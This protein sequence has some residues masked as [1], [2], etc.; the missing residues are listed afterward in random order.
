MELV[1]SF[2]PPSSALPTCFVLLPPAIAASLLRGE[3]LHALVLRLSLPPS[4]CRTVLPLLVSWAGG[5]SNGPSELGIDAAFAT[6]IGL[7]DGQAVCA[8]AIHHEPN[9]RDAVVSIVTSSESDYAAVSATAEF[10]EGALLHQI[11]VLYPGL[12]FPLCLPGR[13]VVELDVLLVGAHGE[14]PDFLYLHSG[15]DVTVLPPALPAHDDVAVDVATLPS[16]LRVLPVPLDLLSDYSSQLLA[17][18]EGR[19]SDDSDTIEHH[20]VFARR[21]LSVASVPALL[22][23]SSKFCVPRGHVYVPPHIWWELNLAMLDSL[24][25]EAIAPVIPEKATSDLCLLPRVHNDS[26]PDTDLRPPSVVYPGML[27]GRG[28]CFIGYVDNMPENARLLDKL[29]AAPSLAVDDAS[30]SYDALYS[31]EPDDELEQ[32]AVSSS[33]SIAAWSMSGGDTLSFQDMEV[34]DTFSERFLHFQSLY[35]TWPP[36]QKVESVCRALQC[37]R[38]ESPRKFLQRVVQHLELGPT[39]DQ[40]RVL[41]LRGGEG[42]GK[43]NLA[44]ACAT[45]LRHKPPMLHTVWVRWRVHVGEPLTASISRV[46]AAFRIAREGSPSLIVFDDVDAV[47]SLDKSTDSLSDSTGG[48]HGGAANAYAIAHCIACCLGQNQSKVRLLLLAKTESILDGEL[49]APG[50]VTCTE[51]IGALTG[52]DRAAILQSMMERS[53]DDTRIQRKE[54]SA[55]E[56]EEDIH[57]I[58]TEVGAVC[59]GFSPRDLNRVVQRAMFLRKSE[60][61]QNLSRGTVAQ[62]LADAAKATVP[63]ARIGVTFQTGSSVTGQTWDA[64]GGLWHAKAALRETF[65]LPARYPAMFANAPVRIPSGVLLYGPPGTGKS[66]LAT[67]GSRAC[68]LRSIT[69][70][71][72]EL[73][74]K[75]IGESEAEVRRLF[76]RASALSPCVVIF[77]ELDA[78]APR[79]GGETTGVAD[80]VVNTLLTSLDGVEGLCK[81]VFVV[82]T[83]SHP[84]L[85]DPAILRPGRIDRWVPVDF[86]DEEERGEI[87]ACLWKGMKIAD[88]ASC[89]AGLK[90]ISIATSGMSG[91]D[92]RGVLSDAALSAGTSASI[93]LEKLLSLVRVARP[94]VSAWERERYA[95][96][97]TLFGRKQQ[98][99]QGSKNELDG[100]RPVRVALQ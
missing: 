80:R 9:V 15:V 72:P 41:L 97:M 65:D 6:S 75:Y 42:F 100:K 76:Q 38:G 95:A 79:R 34:Q 63:Q 61:I 89:A 85:I 45:I 4:A 2:N 99:D 81:G 87:L 20:P 13:R 12:T 5:A 83:S 66:L 93:S 30:A 96:V 25:I 98:Q 50:L 10:T 33:S 69:V 55:A 35:R 94:S 43:T 67:I 74:S 37:V 16:A 32:T 39:S 57:G 62:S 31:E 53:F 44:R 48:D 11:R 77:D 17:S 14:S 68:G 26:V 29:N 3:G 52:D 47:V 71:G 24:R 21:C 58:V 86:P 27:V 70:K 18:I 56:N 28:D 8:E 36:E 78:L 82:A 64:V 23:S 51:T 92:I 49:I 1:V 7:E 59:D 73:L 54:D 46:Q 84:E 88:D 60:S 19:G 22:L 91:A 40:H 90:K